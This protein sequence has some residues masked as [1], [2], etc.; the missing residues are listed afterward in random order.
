MVNRNRKGNKRSGISNKS[1]EEKI[2]FASP[3]HKRA[4]LAIT[5]KYF[6]KTRYVVSE[7]E[8]KDYE[9]AGFKNLLICPD[10]VSGMA[11]VRNWIVDNTKTSRLLMTDDDLKHLMRW[12][13][14]K[15]RYLSPEEADEFVEM[16]FFLAKEFGVKL[17]G[18]SLIPDKAAYREMT[19][20]SLS[21]MILGP[22]TGFILP[23]E[24]RYDEKLPLK[25]DYDFCIQML[26]KYRKI[27][28]F[29][30][31]AYDVDLHKME[32]G[33]ST[34]RTLDI[35]KAQ[36]KLLRKKWGGNI[37]KTDTSTRPWARREKIY[38]L[39]PV[40]KVPIPGI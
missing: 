14:H 1:T 32:G 26:N 16:G 5:H 28:R 38:D 2:T 35:E 27:L 31:V 37:V 29:N 22:F 40:V 9:K 7:S 39:N 3:S 20:F 8:A 24:C 23:V 25:E 17:W 30:Y 13:N 36:L 4:H 12:D 15:K 19:P 33:C 11:K 21:K 10:S 6:P 18:I 34:Y